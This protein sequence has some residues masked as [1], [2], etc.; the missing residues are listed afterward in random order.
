MKHFVRFVIFMVLVSTYA[1]LK[2]EFSRELGGY[3][4][5]YNAFPGD[6]LSVQM[7][8]KYQLKRSKNMALVNISVVRNKSGDAIEGVAARVS[9]YMQNLLGQRKPLSFQQVHEGQ[10]Y[11]YIAQV[12]VENKDIVNFYIQIQPAGQSETYSVKFSKQ[13]VTN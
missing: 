1:P 2:A 6:A 5:Y 3:T 13:F 7:T 10:A 11:Y 12:A 4:V 8:Q 9:G